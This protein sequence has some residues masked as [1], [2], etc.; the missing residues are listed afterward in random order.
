M[1]FNKDEDT[2]V[3]TAVSIETLESIIRE[4][5][6]LLEAVLTVNIPGGSRY[7]YYTLNGADGSH[8]WGVNITVNEC[9]S[10]RV[11]E[12]RACGKHFLSEFD[13]KMGLV[14]SEK[15]TG[16]FESTLKGTETKIRRG[17]FMAGVMENDG[18]GIREIYEPRTSADVES[19]ISAV[20]EAAEAINAELQ[21][22]DTQGGRT[23]YAVCICGTAEGLCIPQLYKIMYGRNRKWRID[24]NVHD[25]TVCREV[26]FTVCEGAGYCGDFGDMAYA[27]LTSELQS[28]LEE[29]DK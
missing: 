13:L 16:L 1:K 7:S 17:K 10:Y 4:A 14:K 26:L 9:G 24:V 28:R 5:S 21:P 15:V 3:Y 12:I 25:N 23:D 8:R 18:R 6:R 27:R 11:A 20:E 22:L 29:V 19:I 2:R